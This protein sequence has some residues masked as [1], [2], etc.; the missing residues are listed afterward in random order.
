VPVAY[1]VTKAVMRAVSER[2]AQDEGVDLMFIARPRAT[3]KPSRSTSHEVFIHLASHGELPLSYADELRKIVRYY[4]DDPELS[5]SV[6]AV[7]GLWRSNTDSPQNG[8]P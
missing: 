1:P 5:V 8:S 7:R 4:M 6:V 2:V 3:S